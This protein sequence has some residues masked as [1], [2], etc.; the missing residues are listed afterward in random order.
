MVTKSHTY[1]NTALITYDFL[2][3][4]GIKGIFFS[5]LDTALKVSVF[6]VSFVRIFRHLNWIRYLSVFSRNAGKYGP[7]KLRI[8]TFFNSANYYIK[9]DYLLWRRNNCHSLHQVYFRK[10]NNINVL[11][12]KSWRL[13]LLF[14]FLYS[15]IWIDN[16]IGSIKVPE[17]ATG[18][19]LQEKVFLKFSQNSQQN[20]CVRA[21]FLT[22]LK[23][24]SG[25][26]VFLR[27]LQ[28]F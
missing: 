28:N 12:S 22:L 4:Q 21:S 7:E 26:G 8:R 23:K 15:R 13:L 2:L 25:T 5:F 14:V 19:V 10:H 9:N 11:H 20:T 24:D 27:I 18:G 17:V 3:P 6:R 16:N 1:I